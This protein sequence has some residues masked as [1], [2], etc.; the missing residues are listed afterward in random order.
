MMSDLEKLETFPCESDAVETVLRLAEEF[1]YGNLMSHLQKAWQ[2]R[3]Q[4]GGMSEKSARLGSFDV[5]AYNEEIEIAHAAGR[6]EGLKEAERLAEDA[7]EA[8]RLLRQIG[9][10]SSLAARIDCGERADAIDA[11]LEAYRARIQE[12]ERAANG[13]AEEAKEWEG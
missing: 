7:Q 9:E 3:L 2:A 10:V 8:S 5:S 12:L 6:I 4:A 11:R 13:L 1:G